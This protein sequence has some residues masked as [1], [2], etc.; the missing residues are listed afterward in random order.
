MK[1]GP[2]VS[3]HQA[4]VDLAAAKPHISFVMLKA[5]EGATFTDSAFADRWATAGRLGIPRGAYHFA[6]PG[7]SWRAQADHFVLTLKAA[8]W[9]PGDAWALDMEV[10]DG[11][12]AA[13]LVAWAD[14]WGRAVT[15]ALGKRGLLYTY[16]AFW[17]T[18]MASPDAIPGGM[19]GWWARYA[20]APRA[21]A[22]WGNPPDVWQFSSSWEVP[23]IGP[24]D[25]NRMTDAAAAWIFGQGEDDMF[26]DTDRAMLT[27]LYKQVTGAVAPGQTDFASTIEAVLATTQ[28]LVNEGRSQAGALAQVIGKSDDTIVA[29][30]LA[31]LAA[32]PATAEL[33]EE[34]RHLL[35][36]D[37]T[38]QL[39]EQGLTVD[40]GPLLDAL[41]LRLGT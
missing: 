30:I 23:G 29:G 3:H 41:A 8:G 10:A 27:T 35:A 15:A 5:T 4:A 19:G 6:R 20:A 39:R 31:Y 21:P 38:A 24:C 13:G 18:W 2:D 25:M 22:V 34:A 1:Q 37:V 28:Q 7:G 26:E 16:P 17:T 12:S 33:D 9:Q 11:V 40:A 32:N 14:A 36:I